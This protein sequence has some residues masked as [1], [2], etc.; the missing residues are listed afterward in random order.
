MNSSKKG[1]TYGSNIAL[2]CKTKEWEDPT[3]KAFPQQPERLN[4]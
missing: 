1:I 2:S 3:K 4:K